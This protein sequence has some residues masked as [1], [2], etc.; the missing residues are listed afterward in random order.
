[1]EASKGDAFAKPIKTQMP[2]LFIGKVTRAK[3]AGHWISKWGPILKHIIADNMGIIHNMSE[4][5][6]TC[7]EMMKLA[8]CTLRMISH[9]AKMMVGKVTIPSMEVPRPKVG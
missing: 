7:Q 2:I 5:Q 3:R 8:K 4:V 1:M 9:F 6:D